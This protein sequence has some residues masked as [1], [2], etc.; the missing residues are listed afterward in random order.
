VR[1]AAFDVLREHDLTTLFANP[2]STEIELLSD[3]PGDLRFVLGL[4][5]SSV[6]GMA[7]GWAIGR[8][9]P[10]LAILHTTPGL[11]NA[12]SA[13]A[14]ARVNRV[15]LVILVGQQDR[16]HIASEPFLTGRLQGLAGDYP[17]WADQPL[18]AQSV[19][20]S[21][22][23][24]YHEAVTGRGPALVI[25]PMDDWAAE[26]AP[27][28]E[29]AAPRRVVR[30]R[31]A[32]PALVAELAELVDRATSPA[33]VVGAGID[34]GDAWA[35][36]AALADRLACPVWQ[37]SF[38]GRAGFPQDHPRFAG[39]LGAD[40]P[41]L[42]QALAPHD[43]VLAA[44]AP[45]FRQYAFS[46]GPFVEPG[47]TVVVVSQDPAE[48]HRSTADLAVL[49][50]PG[51]VCA[52]LVRAVEAREPASET[53]FARPDPPDPPGS[54]EPLRAGHVFAAVA[55]RLAADAV[56]FEE[57]PSNRPELLTRL[58]ARQPLGSLSPAMG[59]LGF[60][61]PAAT[62][63]RMARPD[64]PVVAFVGDGSSL[65]SIQSLWSAAH[66]G[67]GALFVIL[68]NGGYAVMDR[69]AEQHGG[70]APWPGFGVDVAGL[71]RA[72]G[73]PARTVREHEEL[74]ETLDEVVPGL[75]DRTEPLVL[76]V[77]IQP[78]ESFAP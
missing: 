58:P 49:A 75:A 14:T 43:L 67:A 2:G 29:Q 54:G 70:T 21:I 77:V 22:A 60:A 38:S 18:R 52:E 3:L 61:L 31:A 39:H 74:L 33:I 63:V 72:F 62:G 48:V 15:P 26:A 66:Y 45:A 35:A 51:A 28:E 24:A 76:E 59:G 53:L 19:P 32:D 27:P 50:S 30:A 4:H 1:D 71:A 13:I 23:R 7:T 17:V 65:Y 47:T 25:V 55:E 20:A 11:G 16:R 9:E 73:C 36:V 44:G 34:D 5:E 6:V 78:D 57:S 64:L 12:V 69:L 8:G 10:A 68:S 41:R 56:V 40:R 46:P 37:E 42:R